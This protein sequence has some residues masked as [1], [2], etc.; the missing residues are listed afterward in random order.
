MTNVY[1]MFGQKVKWSERQPLFIYDSES[2]R[3]L[4]H[5]NACF[6]AHP[7]SLSWRSVQQEPKADHLP[8]R[9]AQFRTG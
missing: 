4:H 9:N 8:L 5:V 3:L 2:D 7:S 1:E 6:W